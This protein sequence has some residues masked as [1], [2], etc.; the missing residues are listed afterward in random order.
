MKVLIFSG[1]GI[2]AESGIDTYRD[3]GGI[4]D[5]Y[6]QNVVCTLPAAMQNRKETFAFFNDCLRHF[7]GAKPN[8]AHLA[9]ARM[10]K[11]FG[12]ENVLVVTQNVDSLF[13]QAGCEEVLHL[14]GHMDGYLCL[15]CDSKWPREKDVFFNEEEPCPECNDSSMVKCDAV[16]FAEQAPAYAQLEDIRQKLS[17]DDFIISVGT[18]FQVIPPSCFIGD[19]L[20]GS[21]NCV[22]IN[23]HGSDFGGTFDQ[24]IADTAAN[25]LP[26]VLA[27]V[28]SIMVAAGVPAVKRGLSSSKAAQGGPARSSLSM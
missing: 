22:N 10:Q 7:E 26:A 21:R 5:K 23:P 12:P 4:W 6:D 18:S 28:S 1:S 11:S 27:Q 25:A 8:A 17:K 16:M 20:V 13:E 3:E 14:H 19:D 15:C 9:V 24:V 2:S